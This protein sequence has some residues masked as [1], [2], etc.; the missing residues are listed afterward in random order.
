M[1]FPNSQSPAR[2]R[3]IAG[4]CRRDLPVQHNIIITII[5]LISCPLGGPPFITYTFLSGPRSRT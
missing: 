5:P 3:R 2:A 4:L 1:N